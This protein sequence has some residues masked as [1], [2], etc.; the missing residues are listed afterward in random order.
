MES[1]GLQAAEATA[2]VP[3]ADLL[4]PFPVYC[5]AS[6]AKNN[7]ISSLRINDTDEAAEDASISGRVLTHGVFF[8]V[9]PTATCRGFDE[10]CDAVRSTCACRPA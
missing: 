7:L 9:R 3:A 8:P 6:K 1:P 10:L 2:D 5:Q 4:Q